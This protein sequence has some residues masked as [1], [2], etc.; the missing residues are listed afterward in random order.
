MTNET[1]NIYKDAKALAEGF[2]SFLQAVLD[3]RES[4]NISLSGGST[5]KVIFKHWADNY[6]NIIDWQKMSFFWGDERCVPPDDTMSNYG[7]TKSFL[8]DSIDKIEQSKIFRIYGENDI[9]GEIKRYESV[10]NKHLPKQNE[11]PCFDIM[12]LGMG[13]DGHTVSIFPDEIGLWDSKT[14]CVEAEHPETKMKRISLTGRVVNNSEN[15]IFLVTGRNKA[16]KVKQIIEQRDKFID[17][18]PASRVNPTHGNL[19]WFLDEEASALL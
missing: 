2:T 6:K 17:I 10:L 7:M 11:L 1:I 8:F 12:M 19:Y 18:Y 16:E 4:L 9:N 14:N 13:D 5:P 15:I 3:E